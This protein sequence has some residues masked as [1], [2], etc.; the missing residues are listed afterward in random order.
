MSHPGSISGISTH[1]PILEKLCKNYS[2]KTLVE[3]GMGSYSTIFLLKQECYVRSIETDREWYK[4]ILEG[5]TELNPQWDAILC[6][7]LLSS[8]KENDSFFHINNFPAL[9]L[10]DSANYLIRH[11]LANKAIEY[12]LNKD[13]IIVIHDTEQKIYLYHE[14]DLKNNNLTDVMDFQPWTAVIHNKQIDCLSEFKNIKT[15]NNETLK[16]KLYVC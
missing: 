1:L 10:I 16:N 13:V 12:N 9:I 3:F 8:D 7:N 11:K 14:I 5:A 6:E 4:A 15:Y 2:F